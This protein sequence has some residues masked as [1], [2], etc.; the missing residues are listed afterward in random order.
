MEQH[1]HQ[2][3]QHVEE[4]HLEYKK[5]SEDQEFDETE[6]EKI[7]QARQKLH[8]FLSLKPL[9]SEEKTKR[10]D[11][12]TQAIHEI[13]AKE[14]Q[15]ETWLYAFVFHENPRDFAI[16]SSDS[17]SEYN[18]KIEKY[19]SFARKEINRCMF[20]NDPDHFFHFVPDNPYKDQI[21]EKV[22][23]DAFQKDPT[24]CMTLFLEYQPEI[25]ADSGL[26][27]LFQDCL[28]KITLNDASIIH[29][30]LL[31]TPFSALKDKDFVRQFLST[32]AQLDPQS[33]LDLREKIPDFAQFVIQDAE[34]TL[35][36]SNLDDKQMSMTD[37]A[38][39]ID[40]TLAS[41]N[42]LH[43]EA[44]QRFEKETGVA[45]RCT[46]MLPNK[47]IYVNAFTGADSMPL[48]LELS[49][50]DLASAK[51]LDQL[52]NSF[53][54]KRNT[55]SSDLSYKD[56]SRYKN[57]QRMRDFLKSY[58]NRYTNRRETVE[59]DSVT[60]PGREKFKAKEQ[61]DIWKNATT[62]DL[63]AHQTAVMLAMD[64]GTLH[65]VERDFAHVAKHI[66]GDIYDASIV[67]VAV[68]N[69]DEWKKQTVDM[70]DI[71]QSTGSS[72]TELLQGLEKTLIQSVQENKKMFMFHYMAHGGGENNSSDHRSGNTPL[73][74]IKLGKESLDTEEFAKVLAK[75][76][77]GKPLC[78][79][80]DITI[81]AESCY[82]GAQLQRMLDYF[83]NN[84]IPVKN[85]RIISEANMT[86]SDG[87]FKVERASSVNER[88]RGSEGGALSYYLDYYYQMINEARAEG[89]EIKPPVGTLG[90]AIQFADLMARSETDN[91]QNLRAYHYSTELNIDQ[92]I[93]MSEKINDEKSA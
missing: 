23:V 19:P 54:A 77:N 68:T 39:L 45:L 74:H 5:A 81:I 6:K 38:L 10:E 57:D 52:V 20:Q 85:L 8:D 75:E 36:Y 34:K 60:R 79:L 27:T 31:Q 86:T 24:L 72:S 16:R 63:P 26:A 18:D 41:I 40:N 43:K 48:R 9:D 71:P 28:K 83:K 46:G 64:P 62:F 89:K 65:G 17:K 2:I 4:L 88:K 42:P 47:F 91:G 3:R 93:S 78:S 33:V 92:F 7:K 22:F 58:E 51:S 32:C 55:A 76:V 73:G 67:G 21:R 87:G 49:Y 70:Q 13:A 69:S 82:S 29:Q 35:S 12:L 11:A 50:H 25:K 15:S 14:K 80:I 66:Y 30:I 84:S 37:R 61:M 59:L 1:E 90:H 56:S 44:I 53:A